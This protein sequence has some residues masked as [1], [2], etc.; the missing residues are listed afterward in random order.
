M[1]QFKFIAQDDP[2]VERLQ[3]NIDEVLRPI[4]QA[5]II[6][7]VHLQSVVLTAGVAN[8]VEHKLGRPPLGWLIVRQRASATIWD[9]QDSNSMPSRSLDLRC[10][11]NVTVDLWI[12]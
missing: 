11:A 4:L 10:S 5:S 6:D 8:L 2:K 9:L 12:F 1:K 7:G 3:Q